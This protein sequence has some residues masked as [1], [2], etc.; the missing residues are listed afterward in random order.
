M[1]RK[2]E[3]VKSEEK[4]NSSKELVVEVEECLKELASETDDFKKSEFFKSYL[5]TASKFW[6]YSC[7]NQ[8]LI[9]A[10]KPKATRVAGFRKWNEL[11]RYVKKGSKAIRILAPSQK[12]IKEL[13]PQT[14]QEEEKTI[15]LF[16]AVNVFDEAQTEGQELPQI[17]IS[18]AGDN[19]QDFKNLLVSFC[20]ERS[21]KVDFKN[22]GVNGLYGY[23][24]GGE[25]VIT[26]TESI[27]TQVNTMIH[28]IAHELLHKDNKELSR[29]QKEIQAEGTAYVVTKHFGMENKSFNYLALYDADHKKIMENLK[30]IAEGAKE[31][32][33][34]VEGG[35]M[36]PLLSLT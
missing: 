25:I 22:L 30:A 27:N 28:E 34:F 8:I 24:K 13:N 5:E 33:E 35:L 14:M 3:Y 12:T 16:F 20:D 32:I 29:Q 10:Q 15:T 7:R 2:N 11:N 26:S 21:I 4:I 31:I 36:L 23:S 6:Q 1:K 19:Y 17:S 18:V 9:L